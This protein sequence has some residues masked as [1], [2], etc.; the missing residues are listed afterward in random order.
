MV[1]RRTLLTLLLCCL[2]PASWAQSSSIPAGQSSAASSGED[3]AGLPPL[4]LGVHPYLPTVF[5]E[6]HFAPLVAYLSTALGRE[7]E[8]V[9]SPDYH[10]HIMRMGRGELDLA[11]MGPAPYVKL[12]DEYGAFPL[13]ARLSVMGAPEFNGVIFTREGSQIRAL[14]DLR[15]KRFAFGDPS[16]TMSHLVPLYLL[17]EA[18]V[19]LDDLAGHNHYGSHQDVVLAVLRGKADAGAVKQEVFARYRR[20]GLRAVVLTPQFSEHLFVAHQGVSVEQLRTLQ[21]IFQ[22]MNA[23]DEGRAALRAIKPTVTAMVPVEDSDYDNLRRII[24]E[25]REQGVKM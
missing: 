12:V 16:S 2:L 18:G 14:E 22:Q 25:M 23:T 24:R 8:L 20:R 3:G 19:G 4:R 9:I 13:I 7:V 10:S 15:G 17:D 1:V 21:Q 5:I 11:Y 6:R